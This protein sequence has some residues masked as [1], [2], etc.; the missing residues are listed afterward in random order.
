MGNMHTD[1][2]M[3][4]G[5]WSKILVLLKHIRIYINKVQQQSLNWLLGFFFRS[6]KLQHQLL[7]RSYVAL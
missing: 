4:V 1:V 5:N 2:S 7:V 6:C 3:V